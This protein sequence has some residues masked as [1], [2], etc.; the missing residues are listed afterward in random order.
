MKTFAL[1]A[2]AS[3]SLSSFTSCL[4]NAGIGFQTPNDPLFQSTFESRIHNA[5]ILNPASPALLVLPTTTQMV[6]SI[7]SCFTKD[8]IVSSMQLL[9]R[10]GGHSYTGYSYVSYD[11]RP[12]ILVDLQYMNGVSVN[13]QTN[14]A[15]V[16]GGATVGAIFA[17]IDAVTPSRSGFRF[18]FPAGSCPTVGIGGHL[19][20]MTIVTADGKIRTVS[21]TSDADLFWALRGGG[22]GNWGIVTSMTLSLVLVPAQIITYRIQIPPS[23][24]VQVALEYQALIPT[25]PADISFIGLFWTNLGLAVDGWYLGNGGAADIANYVK[26]NMPSAVP[27]VTANSFNRVDFNEVALNDP[28]QPGPVAFKA[29]SSVVTQPLTRD[30]LNVIVSQLSQG[31]PDAFVMFDAYGGE[32]WTP[33]TSDTA[34]PWRQGALFTI[35]YMVTFDP[36]SPG[37]PSPVDWIN[38]FYNTMTPLVGSSSYV[39]Y[40]DSSLGNWTVFSSGADVWNRDYYGSN[41]A[42][43][44]SIKMKYDPTN[45]FRYPQSLLSAGSTTGSGST[46]TGSNISGGNITIV[47]SAASRLGG[48]MLLWLFAIPVLV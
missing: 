2:A 15:V 48:L 46:T 11:G 6:A 22:G 14:E 42:Q 8:D 23:A 29:K 47:Q 33:K 19:Q 37:N 38:G 25:A 39:N 35:Q 34:F 27:Y 4:S 9:P 45:L 30:A 10:G 13:V 5:A 36:Q 17:A 44:A 3:A 26:T 18:G 32:M 41:Y 16:G 28:P 43:L 20:D 24:A 40:I 7:V 31:P 1:V 12:F 21:L